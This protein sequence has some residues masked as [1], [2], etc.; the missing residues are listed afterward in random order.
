MTL[1]VLLGGWI[2]LASLVSPPGSRLIWKL[3]PSMQAVI[4]VTAILALALIPI[5]ALVITISNV[6][7]QL[8]GSGSWFHRCGTLIG[9]LISHPFVRPHASLSLLLLGLV[10]VGISLG[11]VRAWRTQ[12]SA[13]RLA[14]T[15]TGEVIVAG[16]AHRFAFTAGLLWPRVVVSEGLLDCT[17]SGWKA[18][19]LAHEQAHRRGRHPLLL[20]VAEALALGFPLLPLRWAA[21]QLRASLEVL[22][23][24]HATRT[25]GDRALV[26][27]AI[28]GL[29]LESTAGAVGFEG[30]E[31]RRVR[32]LLAGAHPMHPIVSTV[33]V[34]AIFTL[35]GLAA[36]HLGHC[37]DAVVG[38][39]QVA[40][41]PIPSSR[42]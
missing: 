35:I 32:R 16:S 18:V 12:A 21:D 6:L 4:S 34:A 2:A 13:R 23:D 19:V 36:A 14:R 27:E 24:E 42:I 30:D 8:P 22:A 29:A 38:S 25:I 11:V 31:V 17:P 26:A 1:A 28:A 40:Q 41:C 15:G 33:L 5:S 3:R 9:A 7:A 10:P 37:G 20:F 39:L